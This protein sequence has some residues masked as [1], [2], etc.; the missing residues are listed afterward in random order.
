MATNAE[1]T[2]TAGTLPVG[3][4]HTSWQGTFNTFVSLL[5]GTLPGE[6]STFNFGSSTPAVADQGKPWI[7]TNADGTPNGLY[8]WYVTGNKWVMF[9]TLPEPGTI[10][11]YCGT[12]GSIPLLNNYDSDVANPFWYNCNGSN[13]TPDLRG[14]CIIGVGQGSGLTDRA[15]GATGGEETHTLVAAECALASHTHEIGFEHTDPVQT[16]DNEAGRAHD[17]QFDGAIF[18][19]EVGVTR[20]NDAVAASNAHENMPPFHALYF[21]MRSNRLY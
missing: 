3:F 13:G 21:I 7:R 17:T 2:F 9:Q 8:V 12:L 11:A 19:T 14:R 10:V 5:A 16:S 1:V 20:A 15:F 18:G 4:C 6:Y